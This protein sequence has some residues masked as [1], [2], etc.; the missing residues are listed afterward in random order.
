MLNLLL[1]NEKDWSKLLFWGIVLTYIRLY[2]PYGINDTDGGFITAHAWRL[3]NGELLYQDNIYIRPPLSILL[4]YLELLLIPE[5]W[6]LFAER[7]FFYLKV[8]LYSY[9][10]SAIL[11][12]GN[13]RWYIATLAFIISVH[14]YPAAAWHT[15]DG[16]LF[17][18]AA[19]Y[20]FFERKNILLAAVLVVAAMLCKQSFYPLAPLFLLLVFLLEGKK[21]LLKALAGILLTTGGY[22]G[23]LAAWGNLDGFIFWTQGSSSLEQAFQHGI[24]DYLS[25]HPFVIGW[26]IW[27]LPLFWKHKYRKYCWYI[28][29]AGLICSFGYGQYRHQGFSIPVSQARWLFLLSGGYLLIRLFRDPWY[30]LAREQWSQKGRFFFR[31]AALLAISWMAAISWGYAFPILFALPWVALADVF[32]RELE[33]GTSSMGRGALRALL[34]LSLLLVFRYS[35]EFVYRDGRRSQMKYAMSEVFP[36]L[37]GIRSNQATYDKYHELKLLHQKYGPV[38]KTLPAFPLANYLTNTASPFPLDW[39]ISV[40]TN[41]HNETLIDKVDDGGIAFFIEKE[42]EGKIKGNPRY[43]VTEYIMEHYQRVEETGYF[44]VYVSVEK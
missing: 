6:E 30:L 21:K 29:L 11:Y 3:C 38:F 33:W 43:E 7:V 31:H 22:L 23:I 37:K 2:A 19:L 34:L 13:R 20:A 36:K 1:I 24:L 9:L 12:K 5:N 17:S 42:Y 16:I 35:Y 25:I 10:G 28:F 40:E 15:I 26:S 39:V 14:A 4:R 18:V 44:Y 32:T 8:A 27:L 41:Q